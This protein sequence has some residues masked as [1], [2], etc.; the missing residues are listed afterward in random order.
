MDTIGPKSD[1][2]NYEIR[3][4]PQAHSF[5]AFFILS[6][7]ISLLFPVALWYLARIC[8]LSHRFW[9][10]GSKLVEKAYSLPPRPF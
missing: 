8:L 2:A 5:A 3:G 10:S 9:L 6:Y 1:F 7:L 4:S